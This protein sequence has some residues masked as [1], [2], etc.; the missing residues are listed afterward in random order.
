VA[1]YLHSHGDGRDIY[2]PT[3]TGVRRINPAAG[4]SNYGV[5][6][7]VDAA[8]NKVPG[9]FQHYPAPAPP[10]PPPAPAPSGT[11]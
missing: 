7:T 5:A 6:D 10:A 1:A 9:S 3:G 8:G 11:P 4:T 2:A